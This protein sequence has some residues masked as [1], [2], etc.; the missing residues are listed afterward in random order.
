ML[1]YVYEFTMK[2]LP[3]YQMAQFWTYNVTHILVVLLYDTLRYV[4]TGI[5]VGELPDWWGSGLS[6]GF[7]L[8]NSI[9]YK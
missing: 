1:Y 2:R 8:L 5:N 4:T 7:F 6:E 9:Q 3:G